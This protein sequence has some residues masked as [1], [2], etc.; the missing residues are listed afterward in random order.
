MTEIARYFLWRSKQKANA[1]KVKNPLRFVMHGEHE[2]QENVRWI[3]ENATNLWSRS[4]YGGRVINFDGKKT[5]EINE[6]HRRTA[7]CC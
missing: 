3:S 2:T 7:T 6:C 5:P 1:E 4:N